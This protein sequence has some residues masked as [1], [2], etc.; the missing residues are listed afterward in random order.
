MAERKQ[1]DRKGFFGVLAL[2]VLRGRYQ[3]LR[4][5]PGLW[6]AGL[7]PVL[8]LGAI[9]VADYLARDAV[10]LSNGPLSTNHAREELDRYATSDEE[11][12]HSQDK[13]AQCHLFDRS[14]GLPIGRLP[15]EKCTACHGKL[16]ERL[17]VYT[18]AAHYVYRSN[19]LGRR[20]QPETSAMETECAACHPEHLGREAS[21]T[22]VPDS[23]CVPCHFAS[24]DDHPE[25][26]FADSTRPGRSGELPDAGSLRFTH[27]KHLCEV[28]I[29]AGT[30]DLE[31]A[32]VF[33]HNAQPDGRNFQ[34]IDFERHCTWCHFDTP[35]ATEAVS[36]ASGDRFG[37]RTAKQIRDQGGL[38]TSWTNF[39]GDGEFE[40]VA[41]DVKK[42]AV[43]HQDPW[44]LHNLRELRKLAREPA[45]HA[46]LLV[47]SPDLPPGGT[48]EIRREQVRELYEEALDTL[49]LYSRELG[50]LDDRQAQQQIS[51][52]ERYAAD[53]RNALRD[54]AVVLDPTSFALGA[55]RL[56]SPELGQ[57]DRV[58]G[59]LTRRCA[60]ECHVVSDQSVTR[61]QKDQRILRRAEF[62]HRAHVLD[63]GC[64]DCHAMIPIEERL[65]EAMREA[66]KA[67][68]CSQPEVPS[69]RAETQNLPRLATCKD[70]HTPTGAGE[71]CVTCHYFHP[72]KEQR[73]ELVLYVER[74]Q[75]SRP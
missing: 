34:P 44:I 18:Y 21:I 55:V 39:I 73:S 53:L 65:P 3:G 47:A 37:V 8:I 54:P 68:Q 2:P 40:I 5:R 42:L 74:S 10:L 27:V 7:I 64:L 17:N 35:E 16:Q 14:G 26:E 67:G 45:P 24:F 70:C 6:L 48:P 28:M 23:R 38:G 32:C 31:R 62:D 22:D 52:I 46:D 12:E 58:V 19:D 50:T 29:R 4:V 72:N 43:Y 51:L 59:E 66:T 49:A 15:S 13:C 11:A 63:A 69:D 75:E 60:E 9:V 71:R 56:P 41:G 57:V 20:E 36:L 25:F 61:V 1:R 33:C 30:T